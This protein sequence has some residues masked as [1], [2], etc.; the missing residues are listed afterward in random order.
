VY[1][2]VAFC[3]ILVIALELSLLLHRT[4]LRQIDG[5]RLVIRKAPLPDDAQNNYRKCSNAEALF[6]DLSDKVA[7]AQLQKI[8]IYVIQARMELFYFAG[9]G[10]GLE[11]CSWRHFSLAA[12]LSM[13]LSLT[14][15]NCIDQAHH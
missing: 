5:H 9:H 10:F 4:G 3:L 12:E 6:E 13:S 8:H 2:L 15:N 14:I 1:I 11:H 7:Y